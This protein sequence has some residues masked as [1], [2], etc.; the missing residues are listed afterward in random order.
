[1]QIVVLGNA[2][3]KKELAGNEALPSNEVHWINDP[4]QCQQY[5]SADTYIDLVFEPSAERIQLLNGLGEKLIIVNSVI[6]TLSELPSSF[7]RINGWP[8]FLQSPLIEGSGADEK[9]K[10][11]A[12]KVLAV[13]G[14]KIE[15]LPDEPGFV[16]ARVVSLIINEAFFALA[17][18]VSTPDEIDTA[19]KL[20]TAYPYGPFEWGEKIGLQNIVAL[21]DTLRKTQPRYAPCEVLVQKAAN[22][23]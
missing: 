20:G 3:T 11:E 17:E 2:D 9:T 14:K 21:L 15:W 5:P 19:M 4:A 22:I 1:M 10:R 16:T 7:I 12:E 18:G 6:S 8:T 23:I 13:F